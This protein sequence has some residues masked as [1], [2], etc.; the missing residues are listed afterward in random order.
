MILFDITVQWHRTG[1]QYTQR[2][3]WLNV[4]TR[5]RRRPNLKPIFMIL[6]QIHVFMGT[7]S[8]TM[9]HAET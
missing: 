1:P 9:F 7:Y 8:M 2:R 5:Q 3:C 4:G 6:V